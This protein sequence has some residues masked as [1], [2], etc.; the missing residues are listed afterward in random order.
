LILVL[1]L[2][3]TLYPERTFVESGMNAVALWLSN[4]FGIPNESVFVSLLSELDRSG[5]GRVFD[6]V[7][8]DL[9]LLSNENI[10]RCVDIYR[11]HTPQI[12]LYPGA[13]EVIQYHSSFPMYLVTDGDPAM[14][15]G[16][17]SAL[18]IEQY[19]RAVFTTWSF[20]REFGKPSLRS[21]QEIV[22]LE[23]SSLSEIIYVGDDPSK[24]FVSLNAVGAR[25]IR[26]MSG[27][28]ADVQAA[29]DYDAQTQIDGIADLDLYRFL[30]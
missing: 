23:N 25:T 27:C 10:G 4:N 24:D 22:Q 21:F 2:D 5:R 13:L 17:V 26:V 6:T 30:D 1:D 16:K 7:L 12:E 29:P 18:S 11:G 15:M 9:N 14:Q 3:D 20:G 8:A 28:F 19:F